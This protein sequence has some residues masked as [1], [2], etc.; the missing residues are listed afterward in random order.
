MR[1][2]RFYPFTAM[3]LPFAYNSLQPDISEYTMYFHHDK[4]YKGYVDKLNALLKDM[5]FLQNV[6][7]SELTKNENTDIKNNAG[8]VFNHEMYFASLSPERRPVSEFI[9]ECLTK[10]FGSVQEFLKEFHEA[11]MSQ[12]GS[13]YAWL[14]KC[15]GK[16]NKLL[17]IIKTANQDTPDFITE[18]P[19]L[20]VDVWEHAYYLDRQNRRDIYLDAFFNVLN[21][22]VIEKRIREIN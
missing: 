3:P 4:H 13:G 11:G 19:I 15:C 2:E 21:W 17:K 8:G 5:P 12:F 18:I 10:N 20:P 22:D 16:D 14:I 1:D 6:P 9:A 7:L